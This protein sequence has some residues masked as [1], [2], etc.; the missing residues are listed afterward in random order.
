MRIYTRARFQVFHL[1][2][3]VEKLEGKQHRELPGPQGER[4]R[5]PVL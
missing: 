4:A 3:E 5:R 2:L 1:R